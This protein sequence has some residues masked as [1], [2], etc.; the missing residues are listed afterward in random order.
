MFVRLVLCLIEPWFFCFLLVLFVCLLLMM[1]LL[2]DDV[3]DDDVEKR[4]VFQGDPLSLSLFLFVLK[5]KKKEE[6]KKE[7]R[8]SAKKHNK[9]QKSLI[10]QTHPFP[11]Q[12]IKKHL[13]DKSKTTIKKNKKCQKRVSYSRSSKNIK[14]HPIIQT[15]SIFVD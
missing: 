8:R 12:N 10:N 14:K 15:T 1:M 2:F 7:G 11:K 6:R 4:R 5:N 3:V 9:T 13:F